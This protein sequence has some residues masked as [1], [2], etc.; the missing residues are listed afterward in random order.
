MKA[1]FPKM[2]IR[3]LTQYLLEHRDDRAA[4]QTL[5]EPIDAQPTDQVYND[6][7]GEIFSRLLERHYPSISPK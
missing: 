1:E 2:T 3:D 5:M 6:V 7:D 4:F